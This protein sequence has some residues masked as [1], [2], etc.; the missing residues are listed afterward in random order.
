MSRVLLGLS[1]RLRSLD[2]LGSNIKMHL[3]GWCATQDI[4]V[5][6]V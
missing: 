1:L 5:D 2:I 3:A 6:A 4:T